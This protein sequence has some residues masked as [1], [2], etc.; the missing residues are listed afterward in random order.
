MLFAFSLSHND[1]HNLHMKKV[2]L[3]ISKAKIVK[4]YTIIHNYQ[5]PAATSNSVDKTSN[6]NATLQNLN[7]AE[8]K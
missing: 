5:P 4:Q 7:L 1:L 2:G 6:S 8:Q 3:Q